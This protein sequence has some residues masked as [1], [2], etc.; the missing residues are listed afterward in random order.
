MRLIKITTAVRIYC[1]KC[2][3]APGDG[4][5][6]ERGRVKLVNFDG[7]VGRIITI[8]YLHVNDLIAEH[9]N[10]LSRAVEEEINVSLKAG[11]G[12]TFTR[13][14]MTIRRAD[15]NRGDEYYCRCG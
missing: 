1:G 2:R 15:Q 12:V 8:L 5:H 9:L 14:S 6:S 4:L 7:A 10:R 13:R 3:F 11:D